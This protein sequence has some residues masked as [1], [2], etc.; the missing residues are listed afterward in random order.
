[1]CNSQ[2]SI[3]KL[4]KGLGSSEVKE[5]LEKYGPNA[6]PETPSPSDLSIFLSQLKSPLVYILLAAGIVTFV[7][8]EISDTTIILFAVI[9]NTILGF[10]Q[11]R[12]ANKALYALKQ[13]IH[14]TAHVMRDGKRTEIDV[15]ELVPGDIV[16]LNQ[17]DKISADGRLIEANRFLV[18]EAIL[19]G[20]SVPVKKTVED[21]VFMGTIVLAGVGT[22]MVVTTG[23][24]TKIGEI[25]LS[26]QKPDEDTPLKKQ[27]LVFSKQI[28]ILVLMLLVFVF[29]TGLISGRDITEIFTA[30]V[31]LAVS[32][33]PEGLLIALT[34]VLAIGMRKI[35]ARRGLVRTLVSAE[36]LG[37]VTTICVDKTG[38]LTAGKMQVVDIVGNEDEIAKQMLLANDLDDPIVVV[39]FDW[40]RLRLKASARQARKKIGNWKLEIGKL[41]RVHARLDSIPFSSEDRFFASLHKWSKTKNM[42]Y[43]NGAPEFLLEW[44]N[45]NKNQ[46]LKIENQIEKLTKEGK[47]IVGL[48]RKEVSFS[49]TSLIEKDVKKSLE[50]V[51]IIAF[52]DPIRHGVREAFQKTKEAGIKLIVITGDYVQTAVSIMNQLDVKTNDK[53]IM[54]GEELKGIDSFVL[55]E[56]LSGENSINLFAR[57]TPAQKL[58]IVSVLKEKGEVVAMMGDGVND[59]PALKKADI[60][61]VVGEATDVAKESADLVLL[62]SSF[63]TIVAAIEEGRGIFDNIRKIILYLMSDAFEGIF[64]VCGA[65]ILGFPLPVA[66]AQILWINLISDGFPHLALTIDPKR[67]GLM[68][69]PPRDSNEQLVAGWMRKLILIVSLAGGVMALVLF[70]YYYKTT[71]DLMLARSVTFA[72]LGINSLIYVFSVRTL[73]LPF[74]KENP[75]NNKWLNLAVVIGLFFQITPFVFQPLGKFLKVESLNLTQWTFV[76][77][78][79]AVMFIIIEVSKYVFRHTLN[80]KH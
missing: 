48:A 77:T 44:S 61:I 59:A 41:K 51:G 57:T 22:M 12:K 4:K 1:M 38:T 27:L 73:Q 39:A 54:L 19:T 75:L 53:T 50:W 56:K 78:A 71:G 37:G 21:E 80:V 17:G 49:K 79:S 25:A 52:A 3:S 31:A 28:S 2:L 5:L 11:E 76:F 58:K 30:S 23:K 16:I 6:L 64:A 32:S 35:L 72:T 8:K 13:L 7:L 60:G 65:I 47:R 55:S 34:V 62:D 67:P 14:P 15:T 20:E 26:V 9:L 68:K 42:V 70:I 46:K 63:A 36:T 74:W 29:T 24:D 45:L 69:L 10:I 33:I 18:E 66:A 43:V 40:A